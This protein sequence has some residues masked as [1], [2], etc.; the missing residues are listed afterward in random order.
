[1]GKKFANVGAFLDTVNDLPVLPA[2]IQK[3]TDIMDDESKSAEDISAIIAADQGLTSKVL[4]IANS[5]FYGRMNQVVKISESVV[6]IGILNM[7]SMLYAIFM[8]QVYGG[9]KEEHGMLS[10]MWL[11]SISTALLSQKIM[12]KFNPGEKDAAYTA[13]LIHDIGELIILKYEPELFDEIMSEVKDE[14]TLSRVTVEETVMGFSHSDL[15]AAMARKWALPRSIKNAI[16]FHHNPDICDADNQ[17]VAAVH[18]ADAICCM[19]GIAGTD[20][21]PTGK[22]LLKHFSQTAMAELKFSRDDLQYFI[23]LMDGIKGEA[24][25]LME[26][27]KGGK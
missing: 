22:N 6:V 9:A 17:V 24:A 7:K 16:F 25:T 4:K 23:G 15:G 10:K 27:I 3:I 19:A 5:A 26:S 20:K 14:E 13:G 8:E 11:H 18:L 1:M 12:E 21:K 2:N